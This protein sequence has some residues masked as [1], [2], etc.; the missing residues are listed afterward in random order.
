[1]AEHACRAGIACVR[2]A[3][4]EIRVVLPAPFGP[5][6]VEEP[7]GSTARS[8]PGER[9]HGAET[10]RD[11]EDLDCGRHSVNR[12]APDSTRV[13][14]VNYGASKSSTPLALPTHEACRHI[15]E[16]E[17]LPSV[18]ARRRQGEQHP[19]AAESTASSPRARRRRSRVALRRHSRQAPPRRCP[20]KRSG[21]RPARARG[22]RGASRSRTAPQ[23]RYR[24][25]A[26]SLG[27]RPRFLSESVLGIRPSTPELLSAS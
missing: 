3:R 12:P 4:I 16:G 21:D 23:P 8:D 26:R 14:Q 27:C 9:L 18:A 15:G 7:P 20:R 17:C 24:W 22:E 6:Q 10:A 11:V 19:T 1:V 25:L 5:E 2:P 13:R